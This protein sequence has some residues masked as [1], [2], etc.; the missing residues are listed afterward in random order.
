MTSRHMWASLT[1]EFSASGLHKPRYIYKWASSTRIFSTKNKSFGQ[2]N[3]QIH[4]IYKQWEM[5]TTH[6]HAR[7][8][9]CSQGLTL[10]PIFMT[11]LIQ[12]RLPFELNSWILLYFIL[13]SRAQAYV[14]YWGT[15][16]KCDLEGMRW[17]LS[18]LLHEP[19]HA[20]YQVARD[21]SSTLGSWRRSWT[22]N[23]PPQKSYYTLAICDPKFLP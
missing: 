23:F 12:A 22:W 10:I 13:L 19:T 17:F 21:T 4:N 1:Q 3:S 16:R 11:H 14:K 9:M 7:S 5:L 8:T 18:N 15:L 2:T 6:T 20:C